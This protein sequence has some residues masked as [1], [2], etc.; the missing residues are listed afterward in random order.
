MAHNA[1]DAQAFAATDRSMPSFSILACPMA[2]AGIAEKIAA[3]GDTTPIV[4]VTA[5]DA[6]DDR[7]AGLDY[8]ADDY[9]AKPFHP[10]E[11][12]R[13]SGPWSGAVWA[14]LIQCCV[15]GR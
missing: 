3:Q 4:I 15:L 11:L 9:M 8:G 5:R 13:G 6:V 7:V 12:D 2:M 14:A 10:R 1:E